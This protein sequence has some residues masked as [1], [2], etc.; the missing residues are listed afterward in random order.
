MIKQPVAVDDVEVSESPAVSLM[1]GDYQG[2]IAVVGRMIGWCERAVRP[3]DADLQKSISGDSNI[4][5]SG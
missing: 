5:S 4:V 3:A 1:A 2:I